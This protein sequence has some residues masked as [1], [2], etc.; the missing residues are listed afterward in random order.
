MVC[1]LMI[2]EDF[3][4]ESRVK[5]TPQVLKIGDGIVLRNYSR[6][7]GIIIQ[8]DEDSQVLGFDIDGDH[9]LIRRQDFSQGA[10]SERRDGKL[11]LGPVKIR[12][13][14]K[15]ESYSDKN[16]NGM[17]IA[18]KV[19]D[20]EL[21]SRVASEINSALDTPELQDQLHNIGADIESR[22]GRKYRKP[23]N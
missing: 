10:W 4:T 13:A 8:P 23:E 20:R 1:I 9:F 17:A 5:K 3:S 22:M 6:E 11:V 16:G 14:Y 7:H 12:T 15:L 18:K 21:M 2:A 19:K